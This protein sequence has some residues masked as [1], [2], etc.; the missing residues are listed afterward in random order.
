MARFFH[1]GFFPSFRKYGSLLLALSG[2]C[3]FITGLFLYSMAGSADSS[4]MYAVLFCRVSIVDL[5]IPFLFIFSISACAVY[6]KFPQ[7]LLAV[8]FG[9]SALHGF[10]CLFLMSAF[11]TAGW[12]IRPLAVFGG[13]FHLILLYWY[14]YRWRNYRCHGAGRALRPC[15]LLLHHAIGG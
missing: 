15:L 7:M 4:L 10:V 6:M 9:K 2:I 3:G 8:C 14:W 13:T 11:G 5:M 1:P 12:L